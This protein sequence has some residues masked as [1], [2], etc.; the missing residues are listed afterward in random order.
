MAL[1]RTTT[2][3]MQHSRES[4]AKAIVAADEAYVR[5]AIESVKWEER[6]FLRR[7]VRVDRGRAEE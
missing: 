2:P 7:L 1:F 5:D 4:T 3:D 6:G